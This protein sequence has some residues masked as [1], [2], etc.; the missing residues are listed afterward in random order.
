MEIM[1]SFSYC[2]NLEHPNPGVILG[3]N[4]NYWSKA[5]ETAKRMGAQNI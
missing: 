1:N 4:Y 5:Y 3:D 2:F